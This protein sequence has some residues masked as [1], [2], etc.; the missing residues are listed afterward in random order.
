MSVDIFIGLGALEALLGGVWLLG[1]GL[2]IRGE[3]HILGIVTA[4]LGLAYLGYGAGE[5][6]R[7]EP[8]LALGAPA[9]LVLPFWAV[10]LG[11][12]ILRGAEWAAPSQEPAAA[13][14]R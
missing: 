11:S 5:W 14:L 4:S 12:L 1:S 8:Q 2:A 7:V 3:R 9:F 10:W 6:L 13:T